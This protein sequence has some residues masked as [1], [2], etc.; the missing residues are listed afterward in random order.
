MLLFK[1]ANDVINSTLPRVRTLQLHEAAA[2]AAAGHLRTAGHLG[3]K[4]LKSRIR[5]PVAQIE[6][7][8]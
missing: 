2:A 7:L 4:F 1:L 3:Q 8:G 6:R 5:R